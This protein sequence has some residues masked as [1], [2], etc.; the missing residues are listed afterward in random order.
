[1]MTPGGSRPRLL[2]KSRRTECREL[3]PAVFTL[4]IYTGPSLSEAS[5]M[6]ACGNPNLCPLVHTERD[7]V[8]EWMTNWER[9]RQ[10]ERERLESEGKRQSEGAFKGFDSD[11]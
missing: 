1:M 8:G 5:Q 2:C 3:F 7:W 11:L 10:T 4:R 9:E 6:H